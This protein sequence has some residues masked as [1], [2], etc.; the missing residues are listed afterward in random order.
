MTVLN[1]HARACVPTGRGAGQSGA[2]ASRG[3]APSQ[4]KPFAMMQKPVAANHTM[5]TPT[6]AVND[7]HHGL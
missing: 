7:I 5:A 3:S 4:Y 6:K 1:S 2:G